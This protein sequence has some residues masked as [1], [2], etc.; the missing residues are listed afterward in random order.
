MVLPF[1]PLSTSFSS[2][3][4]QFM[5][6]N[7]FQIRGG[8]LDVTKEPPINRNT[9][10]YSLK[11]SQ[12]SQLPHLC[13]H[14]FVSLLWFLSIVSSSLQFSLVNS[15]SLMKICMKC[16]LFPDAS[17]PEITLNTCTTLQEKDYLGVFLLS[18]HNGDM[19]RFYTY[20]HMVALPY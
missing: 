19:Y 20:L 18:F 15:F 6:L 14:H 1:F 2:L 9:E 8:K 5:T 13:P 12:S 10:N 17:F 11:K 3:R 16:Y 7:G 4:Y